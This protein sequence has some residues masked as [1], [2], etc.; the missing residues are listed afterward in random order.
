MACTRADRRTACSLRRHSGGIPRALRGEFPQA[1]MAHFSVTNS[2]FDG[3]L[4]RADGMPFVMSRSVPRPVSGRRGEKSK[5]GPKMNA[6]TQLA[7]LLV[8]SL[9]LVGVACAEDEIPP[10][11]KQA[12]RQVDTNADH[13]ISPEEAKEAAAGRHIGLERFKAAD[14]NNDR[15]LSLAECYAAKIWAPPE[16]SGVVVPPATVVVPPANRVVVNPPVGPNAKVARDIREDA[17]DR[18]E[19]RRDR[20]EDIRD[21]REDIIDAQH[22]GGVAD[23]MEDVRDRAEDRRDRAEDVRDRREDARDASRGVPPRG[24]HHR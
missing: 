16:G 4:K 13:V 1:W 6:R 7:G 5:G 12:F 22:N 3:Y 14:T 21:R 20:A 8:M 17:R 23:R 24:G 15:R 19:D 18:A 11:C 2:Y 10:F 9:G